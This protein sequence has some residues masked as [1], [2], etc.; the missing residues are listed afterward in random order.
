MN[1]LSLITSLSHK[2]HNGTVTPFTRSLRRWMER[3]RH[4]ILNL[5]ILII[6]LPMLAI[7]VRRPGLYICVDGLRTTMIYIRMSIFLTPCIWRAP[8][9]QALNLNIYIT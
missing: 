2:Y 5:F 7:A 1:A 6:F 4:A 8:R 9:A 3:A